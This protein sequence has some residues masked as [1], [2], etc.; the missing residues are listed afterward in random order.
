[1]SSNNMRRWLLTA[2]LVCAWA[3]PASAA[4]KFWSPNVTAGGGASCNNGTFAWDAD[5]GT[6]GAA[7]KCWATTSGGTTA[8]GI[9]VSGD[10]VTFDGSSGGGTVVVS[11]PNSGSGA[12]MVAAASITCGA[13]TGTLDFATNNNNVT[14][15]GSSGLNCSG[16]GTRTLNLGTG[17]FTFSSTSGLFSLATN[18][19]LTFSGAGATLLFNQ[20]ACTNAVNTGAQTVGTITYSCASGTNNMVITNTG[21]TINTLN[22]SLGGGTS[23]VTLTGAG[24]IG[25]LNLTPSGGGMQVTFPGGATTTITTALNTNTS[26]AAAV[27]FQSSSTSNATIS[28]GNAQTVNWLALRSITFGGAGA[29]TVKNSLNVFASGGATINPPSG[30][31]GI[32]GGS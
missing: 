25:T 10:D 28:S 4:A 12:A 27:L 8:A 30:G 3:A 14:L 22:L 26:G 15:N 6:A 20:N 21:G 17:T 13:F 9:P 1:M 32:I 2:L 31:V 19:G 18:T 5:S 11:S 23:T 24:T 29:W 7:H 16:A